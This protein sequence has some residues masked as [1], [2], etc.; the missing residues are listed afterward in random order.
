MVR[1]RNYLILVIV[2]LYVEP[3]NSFV[4]SFFRRFRS[5]MDVWMFFFL[6][7]LTESVLELILLDC[8]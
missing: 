7:S 3:R 4:S 2:E 8:G 1:I 6:F 5:K